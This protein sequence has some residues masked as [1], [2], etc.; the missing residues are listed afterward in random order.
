M[1][2][3]KDTKIT[4]FGALMSLLGKVE[5]PCLEAKIKFVMPAKAGI[6]LR[7]LQGQRKPGFLPRIRSGAGSTPE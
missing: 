7:A 2:T 1:F 3:T 5:I 6:H 4:K